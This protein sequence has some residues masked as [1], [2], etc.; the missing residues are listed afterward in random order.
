MFDIISRVLGREEGGGAGN[1]RDRGRVGVSRGSRGRWGARKVAVV[2]RF[3]G[4]LAHF[5]FR[6][7]TRG[8]WSPTSQ[9]GGTGRTP[10]WLQ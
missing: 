7:V 6:F 9:R 3:R 1:T 5:L 4:I 2:A 8:G 10:T